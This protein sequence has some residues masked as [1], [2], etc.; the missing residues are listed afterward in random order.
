MFDCCRCVHIAINT[1]FLF[2]FTVTLI[3]Y[4]T[5]NVCGKSRDWNL[6]AVCCITRIVTLL[7][8]HPFA[9]GYSL[10]LAT[11]RT[12][13]CAVSMLH[14]QFNGYKLLSTALLLVILVS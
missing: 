13:G 10:L 6:Q 9:V 2:Q 7:S 5:E 8:A 14:T 1:R 3:A 12:L 11:L 4:Q